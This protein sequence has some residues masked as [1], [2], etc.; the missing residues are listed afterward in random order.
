MQ[1]IPAAMDPLEVNSSWTSE[2]LLYSKG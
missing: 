1:V 2:K